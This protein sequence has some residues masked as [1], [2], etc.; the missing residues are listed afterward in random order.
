MSMQFLT[1]NRIFRF[2][3]SDLFSQHHFFLF[4]KIIA[5]MKYEEEEENRFEV[6]EYS[7]ELNLFGKHFDR[8]SN[9][10]LI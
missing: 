10:R 2:D 9:Q 1:Q 3:S 7:K 8:S 4:K 5:Q 6:D